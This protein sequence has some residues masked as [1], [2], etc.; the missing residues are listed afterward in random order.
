LAPEL[1]AHRL[2]TE[3]TIERAAAAGAGVVRETPVVTTR[4]LSERAGTKV[5]LKAENLQGTGSFK[6]R[7]AMS[8]ITALGD[9]TAA[10]VVCGSAGNHAQAVAYAARARGVPCEVFMPVAAPIAKTEAVQALGATLH[11]GGDTVDDAVAAARERADEAGMQ[12]I[13]PFDDPDVIAGQGGLGLELLHQV[14][15]MGRVVVPV[16][17]GGLI[18]GTAI[19]IKSQRPSVE[20]VGIQVEACS[21][22]LASLEAGVPV[23]VESARTIADGIAVKRPGE[24]TLPLIDVWVDQM[25]VVSEDEVAEAMVFLLERTKL[26]VEGAGAVGVA[27][28]L[29]D[30][31]STPVNGTSVLVL[32]GGNVGAGMLAE[33]AR[34]HET[35]AHRRLVLRVRIPDLPGS[36]A[37]LLGTIGTTGA[38]LLDVQHIREGLDL[39]IQETAVQLVL[40]TRG[41]EHA[42]AVRAAIEAGGYR[43]ATEIL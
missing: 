3:A 25:L 9:A 41:S 8:K 37:A 10:G 39:H 24:I 6:L 4:T 22:F 42:A 43:E 36:L 17:G 27:A 7:G 14:P 12:F 19:A 5:V 2:V 38:N 30:K 15:D 26:V 20:V 16:G 29:A 21:P 23:A 35:Q 18:S 31:L 13:H 32:S 11:L 1:E 28:L 40:E 33:V 34:R